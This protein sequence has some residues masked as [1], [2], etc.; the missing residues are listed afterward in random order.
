MNVIIKY[1]LKIKWKKV[2][3]ESLKSKEINF[4]NQICEKLCE[5]TGMIERKG[6]VAA[7]IVTNGYHSWNE[8]NTNLN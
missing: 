8:L 7:T 4:M 3:T 2:A 1:S 6:F 5:T